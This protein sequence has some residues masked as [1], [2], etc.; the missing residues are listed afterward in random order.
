MT[1]RNNSSCMVKTYIFYAN[2]MLQVSIESIASANE[3]DDVAVD[4][5]YPIL[6]D[7]LFDEEERHLFVLSPNK[8][9]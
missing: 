6:K 1:N 5:G 4:P 8:V 9:S 7:M 2:T 3:Y